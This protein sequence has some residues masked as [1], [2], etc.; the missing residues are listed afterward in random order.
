LG[1]KHKTQHQQHS[2]LSPK[3]ENKSK[4][5]DSVLSEDTSEITARLASKL[6]LSDVGQNNTLTSNM[7][8]INMMKTRI[9]KIEAQFQH[10]GKNNLQIKLQ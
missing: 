7:D 1:T 8:K 3:R 5:D 6:G 9:T 10:I 2:T 4:D